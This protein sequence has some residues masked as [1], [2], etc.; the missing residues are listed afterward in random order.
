MSQL[1]RFINQI[2]YFSVREKE[3]FHDKPPYGNPQNTIPIAVNSFCP[4][5]LY[6]ANTMAVFFFAF[7]CLAIRSAR[8]LLRADS[9]LISYPLLKHLFFPLNTSN[10]FLGED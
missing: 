7:V 9:A 5:N 10:V 6:V 3:V 4:M 1:L 8:T 2:L